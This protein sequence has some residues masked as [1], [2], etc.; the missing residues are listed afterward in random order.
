MEW[1]EKNRDVCC[2]HKS[3]RTG[4]SAEKLVAGIEE[5]HFSWGFY[6]K[7]KHLFESYKVEFFSHKLTEQ[8]WI[9]DAAELEIMEAAAAL[10]DRGFACIL[11]EIRPGR[12]ERE[13]ALALEFALRDW[14]ADGCS[15][16]FIVASGERSSMPHG[17]SSRRV[18][19]QGDLVTLDFGIRYGGYSSDMT[20]TVCLGEP[21]VRQREIYDIVLLAQETGLRALKAGKTGIEV[22]ACARAVIEAAGYG[23]QFGHGLGHGVGISVHETP[24]LNKRDETVLTPGMVVT[25][26]PGIYIPGWGGVRI[27]DMAVV[28]ENEAKVLTQ[29]P[30]TFIIIE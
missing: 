9:K 1:V 2:Q 20:R 22:D 19:Q 30:K 25:V 29:S 27:E 26:E 21:T 12:T 5:E 7:N 14:G 8:R 4:S 13:I 6:T 15:F 28:T 16:E 23:P 10:T 3:D 11:K 24:R 18:M 17:V